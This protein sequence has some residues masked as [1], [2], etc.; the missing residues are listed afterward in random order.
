MFAVYIDNLQVNSD[1]SDTM[2]DPLS[3]LY[4]SADLDS[5]EVNSSDC[6]MKLMKKL[7]VLFYGAPFTGNV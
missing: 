3:K 7:V 4:D 1:F 6:T 2:I 5:T